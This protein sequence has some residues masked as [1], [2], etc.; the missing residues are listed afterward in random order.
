[1]DLVKCKIA[2]RSII[3]KNKNKKNRCEWE[4]EREG[5]T[6]KYIK[7]DMNDDCLFGF[8][9]VLKSIVKFYNIFGSFFFFYYSMCSQREI[10]QKKK[11]SIFSDRRFF[12]SSLSND[13]FLTIYLF[14]EI[15]YY[16]TGNIKSLSNFI[17]IAFK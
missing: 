14:L 6:Q 15:F 5:E 11:I 9:Y 4:R 12:I 8:Y 2:R 10:N 3:K 1:M 13:F 7:N 16:F 17:E